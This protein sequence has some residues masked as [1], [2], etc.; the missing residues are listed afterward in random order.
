MQ[1]TA[2]QAMTE[3]ALGLSM[4]F[5]ALLI[6]A[7]ISVT[8]PAS[9]EAEDK[10]IAEYAVKQ[11]I[12]ISTEEDKN[13]KAEVSHSSHEIKQKVLLF[14]KGQFYDLALNEISVDNYISNFSSKDQ[15][16]EVIVAVNPA[17]ALNELLAIQKMFDGV[18]VQITML[19][20]QWQSTLS[21]QY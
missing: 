1:D 13:N 9:T 17:L 20:A 14:W 11:K 5:F 12:S 7:L 21:T 19:S 8:L 2:T 3:V 4:A 15:V 18:P 16:K 6:L 10:P